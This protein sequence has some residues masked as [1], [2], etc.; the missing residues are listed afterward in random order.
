M[1]KSIKKKQVEKETRKG[2]TE[3][4]NNQIKNRQYEQR[5]N[6]KFPVQ[7]NLEGTIRITAKGL[8]Y[9]EI[10]GMK[11][12]IEVDPRDLGTALDRDRV[13]INL[14]GKTAGKKPAR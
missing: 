12:D 13:G 1:K 3:R 4:N 8:G 9:V 10:E 2:N 6:P 11:D 14:Y 5:E 7:H